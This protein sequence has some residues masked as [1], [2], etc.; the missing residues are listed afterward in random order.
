MKSLFE[1]KHRRYFNIYDDWV[2]HYIFSR[3]TKESKA[4]LIA[5]LNVILRREEDPIIDIQI[6]DPDFY[7]E[8]DQDKESVLDIKALTD[9]NEIIDIEVQNKN[10]SFYCDRTVYYGGRMVNSALEKGED[11]DKMKKSIVISIVNGTLFHETGKLH[12]VFRLREIN[13]GIQLSDRLELHFIELGKVPAGKPVESL[14][15]VER[16]AAYLKFAGD[17]TKEDYVQDL[18]QSG[19]DAIK[20]TEQLFRELTEDEIAYERN[21]RKLKY[22][23]DRNTELAHARKEGIATGMEKGIAAGMEKGETLLLIKQVC[24]KLA[25]SKPAAQ[26][27]AELEEDPAHIEHICTAAQG[28]APDYDIQ[29]IYDKLMALPDKR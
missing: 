2:F 7:G 12:T 4:A 17:E 16:L 18:I 24:K 20:M 19:G 26:I 21:E 3:D 9:S 23:L 15:P 11:Y 1:N 13:E 25:K 27:A 8:R 6:K 10:L 29:E 22:E 28:F 14:T 5:V